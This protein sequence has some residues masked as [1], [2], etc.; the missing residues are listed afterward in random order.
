[1]ISYWHDIKYKNHACLLVIIVLSRDL[2]SRFTIMNYISMAILK[3]PPMHVFFAL[4]K[5]GTYHT[6]PVEQSELAILLRY[7]T[8]QPS[9][10]GPMT[11]ASTAKRASSQ[12]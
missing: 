6:S 10:T 12:W 2:S 5:P 3:L 7:L 1:M 4:P 8:L 9:L 11:F